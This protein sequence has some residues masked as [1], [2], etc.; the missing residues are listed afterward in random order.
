MCWRILM[1]WFTMSEYEWSIGLPTRRWCLRLGV[2]VVL[3]A[4]V[5]VPSRRG[6]AQ[7]RTLY[8][9]RRWG[10]VF[11]SHFVLC[12]TF[13]RVLVMFRNASTSYSVVTAGFFVILTAST[14]DHGLYS[15]RHVFI[16]FNRNCQLQTLEMCCSLELF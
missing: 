4:G 5:A 11:Q 8:N 3:P 14:I 10:S 13:V 6:V 2:A 9:C 12:S 16:Y 15:T 1:V 7:F